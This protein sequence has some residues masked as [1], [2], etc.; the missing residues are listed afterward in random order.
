MKA[1]ERSSERQHG[2]LPHGFQSLDPVGDISLLRAKNAGVFP[3][4]ERETA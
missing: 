4:S 2:I 1:K 3:K